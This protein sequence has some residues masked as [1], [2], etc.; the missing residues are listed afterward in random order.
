MV[1]VAIGRDPG[2]GD[3][4]QPGA[5]QG[6]HLAKDRDPVRCSGPKE[7]FLGLEGEALLRLDRP[8]PAHPRNHVEH[9]PLCRVEAAANV[10]V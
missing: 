10:D 4:K 1:R 8:A 2:L 7:H 6:R 9:A 3:P 5:L